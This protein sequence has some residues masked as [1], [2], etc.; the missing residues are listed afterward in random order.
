MAYNNITLYDNNLD[1]QDLENYFVS[2]ASFFYKLWAGVSKFTSSSRLLYH[3]FYD[4]F[5]GIQAA[6]G[7]KRRAFAMFYHNGL[8]HLLCMASG[9]YGNQLSATNCV[10]LLCN[11][12]LNFMHLQFCRG[13]S[14]ELSLST[15]IWQVFFAG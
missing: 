13:F 3:L 4:D 8:H 5:L 9:C 10:C 2:L 6:I 14:Q 15:R 11:E 1:T 7:K 12:Q